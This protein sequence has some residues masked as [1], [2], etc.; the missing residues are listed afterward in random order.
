MSKTFTQNV[1]LFMILHAMFLGS[2]KADQPEGDVVQGVEN[3]TKKLDDYLKPIIKD[4]SRSIGFKSLSPEPGTK[5][6]RGEEYSPEEIGKTIKDV[7]VGTFWIMRL[8]PVILFVV[9]LF[10]IAG[11]LSC[12]YFCCWSDVFGTPGSAEERAALAPLP[13]NVNDH[14]SHEVQMQ[15]YQTQEIRERQK[16]QYANQ[17][18]PFDPENS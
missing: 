17:Y 2:L 4:I 7:E 18:N 8:M 16:K 15:S 6:A 10:A 3:I 12:C 5:E 13:W 1:I 11:C 9:F 14:V